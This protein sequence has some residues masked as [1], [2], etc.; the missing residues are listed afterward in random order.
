MAE[1]KFIAHYKNCDI[2][3]DFRNYN[4]RGS[5]LCSLIP[6]RATLIEKQIRTKGSYPRSYASLSLY[7]DRQ[8]NFVKGHFSA[9]GER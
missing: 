5:I 3:M 1:V 4:L 7:P 6:Q 2:R 9:Q 8:G